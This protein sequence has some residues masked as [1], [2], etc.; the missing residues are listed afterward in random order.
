MVF[1]IFT[2]N[3][4][5]HRAS[6][7]TKNYLEASEEELREMVVDLWNPTQFSDFELWGIRDAMQKGWVKPFLP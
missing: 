2:V 4:V 7:V 3:S 6:D 1:I 5:G